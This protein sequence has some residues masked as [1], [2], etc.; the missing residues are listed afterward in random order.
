MLVIASIV[1]VIID[2]KYS[3]GILPIAFSPGIVVGVMVYLFSKI[4][5]AQFNPAVSLAF[6][7]DKRINKEFILYIIIQFIASIPASLLVYNLVGSEGELGSTLPNQELDVGVIFGFEILLTTLLMSV[8]LIVVYTNGLR[9]FGGIVIGLII[10]IDIII[11]SDISGA[12]MN[13]AR[14]FGPMII[15]NNIEYL[16]IYLSA[17]FIGSVLTVYLFRLRAKVG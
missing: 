11:G 5:G 17:P 7:L 1:P 14:S 13:P 9:N 4:S 12:S 2:A 15:S 8:I 3:I 6:F 10:A 16:W